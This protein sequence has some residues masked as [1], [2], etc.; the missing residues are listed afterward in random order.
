MRRY[1]EQKTNEEG[2][3]RQ[4]PDDADDQSCHSDARGAAQDQ[5]GDRSPLSAQ[6]Q[7]NAHLSLSLQHT[8]R[9][10]SVETDSCNEQRDTRERGDQPRSESWLSDGIV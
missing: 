1:A 10:D 2:S 7:A 9:K 6:R 4:R 8:I 3:Q 5:A